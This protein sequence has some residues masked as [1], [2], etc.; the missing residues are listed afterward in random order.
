MISNAEA[1]QSSNIYRR[2]NVL[3][4]ILILHLNHTISS[5]LKRSCYFSQLYR[6][7]P[8]LLKSLKIQPKATIENNSRVTTQLIP[9]KNTPVQLLQRKEQENRHL[10]KSSKMCQNNLPSGST[11]VPAHVDEQFH[12]ETQFQ[13]PSTTSPSRLSL[14][15]SLGQGIIQVPAWR[16][17]Y[18]HE[19]APEEGAG[20]YLIA[21]TVSCL[22]CGHRPCP[23]CPK[24]Y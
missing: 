18:C 14:S 6:F 12:D 2:W 20:P 10:P 17:W 13:N 4:S 19:C 23:D 24:E 9:L 1:K 16:I 7:H 5:K 8:P 11:I 21:H 15:W 3:G 22:V